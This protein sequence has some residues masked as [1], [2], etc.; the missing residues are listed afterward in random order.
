VIKAVD[1]CV[2]QLCNPGDGLSDYAF[3]CRRRVIRRHYWHP[4]AKVRGSQAVRER[5]RAF[6][7]NHPNAGFCRCGARTVDRRPQPEFI[8]AGPCDPGVWVE[9]KPGGLCVV[10]T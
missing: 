2:C 6:Y 3:M 7:D 10:P 1:V 5:A 9:R 4:I 8:K